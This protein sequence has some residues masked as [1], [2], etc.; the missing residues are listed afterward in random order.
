VCSNWV[1]LLLKINCANKDTIAP[2]KS[3]KKGERK[4]KGISQFS[5]LNLPS[6]L[7]VLI[8]KKKERFNLL[9]LDL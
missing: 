2:I 9:K 4:R 8:E 7:G 6:I 3:E 5:C 1:I